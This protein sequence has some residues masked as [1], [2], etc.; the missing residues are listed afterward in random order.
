MLEQPEIKRPWGGYTIIKKN[1]V[2][3]VKKLFIYNE[4]RLSLQSHQHRNE[5]WYVLYGEI[6][7]QIGN[8]FHNAKVGDVFYVPKNKKHRI[9]GV[10]DACVLEMSF[11]KVLE[12]D[13][14]RYDDDYGRV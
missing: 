11:G 7:A 10:T 14:I 9:Q 12:N 6:E 4:A 5:V 1:Q 13:C 8:K 3:W 2:Y